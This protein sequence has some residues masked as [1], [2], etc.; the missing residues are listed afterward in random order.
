MHKKLSDKNILNE[1]D[2]E[3]IIKIMDNKK[4]QSEDLPKGETW[5]ERVNFK[6]SKSMMNDHRLTNLKN[7]KEKTCEILKVKI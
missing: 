4:Q 1:E 7:L 2:T 3:E 5:I 6:F